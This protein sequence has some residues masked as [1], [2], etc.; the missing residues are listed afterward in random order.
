MDISGRKIIGGL[1]IISII[2]ILIAF[3]V[4][5]LDTVNIGNNIGLINI[6]GVISSNA[7]GSLLTKPRQSFLS[8]LRA[9]EQ[10]PSIKAL[11]IRIDSPGGTSGTSQELFQA[12]LRIRQKGIPVIVSM[13]DT[14]ASGGYYVASAAD[15]IFANGSTITGSIGVIM[16]FTNLEELY[17]KIGIKYEIIKSGAYKDAGHSARSLT[18]A[19][20]KLF[21]DLIHDVWDQFVTDVTESRG[22]EREKVEALADGRILTG[23]QALEAGLIDEIGGLEEALNKAQEAAGIVGPFRIKS[24]QEPLSWFE[25]ILSVINNVPNIL[26]NLPRSSISI[27]YQY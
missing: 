21:A 10:D 9:A 27:R 1:L 15:Y 22:L 23:R 8:Q 17:N 2:A 14:A 20:E 3:V 11:V 19:E 4:T 24:Y 13:G 6:E 16:E 26:E 18:P 5:S 7:S 25:R 12:V